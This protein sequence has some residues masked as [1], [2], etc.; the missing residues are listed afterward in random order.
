MLHFPVFPACRCLHA[1]CIGVPHLMAT[2]AGGS[3]CFLDLCHVPRKQSCRT[4]VFNQA[5]HGKIV[6]L[7]S[8][9]ASCLSGIGVSLLWIKQFGI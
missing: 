3:D 1:F 8:H 2:I 9:I 4:H 5:R 7:V 6:L